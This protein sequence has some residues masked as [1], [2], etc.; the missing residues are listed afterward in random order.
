MKLIITGKRN[1]GKSTLVYNLC[2]K[3]KCHGV[4]CLP[5]FEN[6]MKIGTDAI[7]LMTGEKKIFSRI[8]EKADYEG[9]EMHRYVINKNGLNHA[10]NAIENAI[11][12]EGIIVIDEFGYLEKEKKGYYNSVKKV[13]NSNKDVIM[14]VRENILKNFIEEFK[15][16]YFILNMKNCID[17]KYL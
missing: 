6:K 7:D 3:C 14:V 11:K 10:I 13:L 4:V 9:I 16:D 15:G 5:V 8:K 17:F 2:K 1:S 12:E